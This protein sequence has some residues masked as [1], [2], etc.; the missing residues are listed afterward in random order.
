MARAASAEVDCVIVGAGYAGL[1]AALRLTQATPPAS[2][3]VLEARPERVGGRVRTDTLDDG[4]WLDL[5]GTWFGPGQD[6]S[7]R[8]AAEMGVCT[9]PTWTEGDSLVVAADG[10]LV[11][12]PEDFPFSALFP[13]GAAALAMAELEAMAGV[14]PPDAPWN[15]PRAQEWDSTTFLGWTAKKF[16]GDDSLLLAQTALHTI[17]SGLFCIHPSELSLLDALYLV[18]SHQGFGHLMLVKGGAQQDRIDG[19]AQAIAEKI[20]HRLGDAVHLGTPVRAIRRD[21]HGVEVVADT[22]TVRGRRAIVAVPAP[23]AGHIAYDPPLPLD[24]SQLQE[25]IALGAVLKV[26]TVYPEPFWRAEQLNGQSFAVNDPVGATFDG[27]A[28]GH[29][30]G[31]LISFA[32]GPHARALGRLGAAARKQTFLDALAR[33]FGARAG[34]PELYHEIEWATEPWSGGGI[35]GHF[36]PGVLTQYGFLLRQPVGPIHW[37][38]TETSSAYHGSINGAI[39]SGERA[40]QEVLDAIRGTAAG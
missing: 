35:F 22:L 38:G 11:R 4:T 17:F 31:I 16:G 37:A 23:L 28:K 32:F 6:Y 9:Y 29:P 2:V 7:Y 15:A 13:A 36:P 10:R 39:E 40:A 14:V 5:G 3:L 25:R 30:R 20:K 26:A 1:T 34:K 8:L 12:H 27:E 21:D 24:R 33:R 18:R 19:G